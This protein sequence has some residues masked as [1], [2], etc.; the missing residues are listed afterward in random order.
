MLQ[1]VVELFNFCKKILAPHMTVFRKDEDVEF[2]PQ[3]GAAVR[4]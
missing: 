4:E 1:Q 3:S 2:D